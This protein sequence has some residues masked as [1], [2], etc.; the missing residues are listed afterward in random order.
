M[1]Q[2]L[3]LAAPAGNPPA[4]APKTVSLIVENM[5]CGSCMARIERALRATPGV[6]AARA[7]LAAKR[8]SV[9]FDENATEPLQL[10]EA[11]ERSGYRAAELVGQPDDR[12]AERADDLLRR[13]GVAGFAAANVMLLSE[14]VWFGAVTD[15]DQSATDLFHWLSALFA[16]PATAYAAQPFF[17][18]ALDGLRARRLNMDVPISLGI[19]LATIMSLFQTIRGTDQ[20]YFDAAISLTFF[21]LIGRYLDEKVRVRARGAAENLLGL[22]ALAADVV[23]ADGKVR[24]LSARACWSPACVCS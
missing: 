20:V 1:D 5:T 23:D 6:S 11:L 14:V 18:S 10:I 12:T 19:G 8:V 3:T 17:R 15:M 4:C 7:S 9:T 2:A 16:M 22:K 13:L 24:R 21:L